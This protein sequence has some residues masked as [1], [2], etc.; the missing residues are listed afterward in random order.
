MHHIMGDVLTA[1]CPEG[2]VYIAPY[3]RG[4]VEKWEY[5]DCNRRWLQFKHHEYLALL[6]PWI[7]RG[8]VYV[9]MTIRDLRDVTASLLSY[10][11]SDFD[12]LV[13]RKLFWDN[14]TNWEQ[15]RFYIPSNRF[16]VVR[17][18]EMIP[19]LAPTVQRVSQHLGVPLRDEQIAT[20][21]RRHT[22]E[23]TRR[24]NPEFAKRHIS[25]GRVGR[26]REHLEPEQIAYLEEMA[27]EWLVQQGYL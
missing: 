19:S 13:K 11:N 23:E 10:W 8:H 24:L 16:L 7:R 14:L 15:W 18:E 26:Y 3:D 1:G 27:G 2:S 22:I 25:D 5:A 9:V 6:Q 21:A 17:Y 20:I 4:F 12:H